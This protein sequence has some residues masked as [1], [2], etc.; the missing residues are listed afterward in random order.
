MTYCKIRYV[1]IAKSVTFPQ[2]G[3]IHAEMLQL[4]VT[5]ARARCRVEFAVSQLE[6]KDLVKLLRLTPEIRGRLL[7]GMQEHIST[8]QHLKDVIP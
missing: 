8:E 2:N 1:Q 4:I 7:G 6:M 3:V 5:H